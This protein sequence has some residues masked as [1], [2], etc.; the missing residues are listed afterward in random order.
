MNIA[1]IAGVGMLIGFSA[2]AFAHTHLVRSV[3]ADR[4]TIAVAPEKFVLTFAEP[5]KLT[6]LSLQKGAEPATKIGALPTIASAEISIPA[7]ALTA[8]RYV[9]S[10]RAIGADGHV[11]PGKITFNVSP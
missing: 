11:M 6:L 1:R 10:W 7:P 4:T 8:G 2:L 5:V 3:P 9:L